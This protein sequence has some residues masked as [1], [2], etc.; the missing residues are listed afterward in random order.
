MTQADD[1][2]PQRN[3]NIDS[4]IQAYDRVLDRT[5]TIIS[6]LH[7]LHTRL[8]GDE[9]ETAGGSDKGETIPNGVIAR[10]RFLNDTHL[11]QLDTIEGIIGSIEEDV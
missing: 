7:G 8:H 6:R 10:L 1:T 4:I 3:P 2:T 5:G 9:P 11:S